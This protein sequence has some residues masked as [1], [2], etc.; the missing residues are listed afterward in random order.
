MAN[1]ILLKRG[2]A[3]DLSKLSLQEGE[4]AI[5]YNAEKNSA[6]LYVGGAEGENILV[7]ADVAGAAAAALQQANQYTDTAVQQTK[8]YTDTTVQE[9]IDA[10]VNG[11]PGT[12]DT[13]LELATAIQTNQSAVDAINTAIT[14]KVDKEAGKGLS[15]ENFTEAEKTKLEGIAPNA[16]NYTHPSSH[17]ATM[18]T[19]DS[20][21]RFVTDSD[22]STWNAKLGTSSTIDGGT[23]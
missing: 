22:K 4:I 9:K 7:T 21:H 2:L 16:N 12:L 18:I 13:L 5:A 17:A 1:V 15:E 11:A 3:T 6:Q 14:K 10:L 8:Q 20:S 23:F 19:E